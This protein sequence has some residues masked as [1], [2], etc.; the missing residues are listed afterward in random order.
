MNRKTNPTPYRLALGLSGVLLGCGTLQAAEPSK[1][2]IAFFESKVRPV[3]VNHCYRCHSEAEGSTKGG[4]AL[5][6]L[7]ALMRGGDSGKAVVPGQ[8]EA[9][10]LVKAIQYHDP[11]LQ[12]PPKEQ[13]TEDQV[14][15]LTQWVIIGAPFPAGGPKTVERSYDADTLNHWA[16][17]PVLDLPTP[18]VANEAWAV[19]D[20]DR[21]ILSKQEAVG[22]TPNQEA[23]KRILLRRATYDLTGLP[24]TLKEMDDF[25]ADN[26]PKAFEKVVDRL[27]KSPHYGE[28]WGRHWLDVARYADTKGDAQRDSVYVYPYAWAYRDYVIKSFNE[29]KPFDLFIKEQIAADLMEPTRTDKDPW[30]YAAL[31]FLTVGNR[32]DG[33]QEEIVNDRIDTLSKAFLGLTVACA[34]CHDHKFDPI[35]TSDYYSWRGIMLSIQ[36]PPSDSLPLLGKPA[37]TPQFRQFLDEYR[38][39]QEELQKYYTEDVNKWLSTTRE[40]AAAFLVALVESKGNRGEGINILR[41]NK[42]NYND[43]R[44]GYPLWQR[45]VSDGRDRKSPLA[46][47]FGPWHE[48][49][50]VPDNARFAQGAAKVIEDMAKDR[51][52]NPEVV[53]AF[54]RVVPRSMTQVAQ[55]YGSIFINAEKQMETELK[56]RPTATRLRNPNQEALRGVAYMVDYRREVEKPF[57]RI[58]RYLP[59]NLQGKETSILNRIAELEMSHP[60]APARAMVVLDK[61]APVISPI[62]IRGE[63]NNRGEDVPHRFLKLFSNGQE[64]QPYRQT[65]SGRLE[66]AQDIADPRNP[67][68][69]RVLVNRV[70]QHHFGEGLVSTPDD[71][72]V[73]SDPPSHPELLDHLANY[74]VRNGW[75]IKKL[76]RYIM[77]SMTYRQSSET[78]PRLAQI[79]PDNK[80]LWRA[81]IR[82]LEFESI[83]DTLLALGGSLDPSIGGKPFDLENE[84]STRRTVYAKLDRGKLPEVLNHFNFANPDMTSGKRYASTVPQQ[85]L[86]MMNS[87]LVV[88]LAKKLVERQDFTRLKET[89]KRI[90]LLYKL[91]YQRLPDEKE[92]QLG[93]SFIGD[94][95]EVTQ[96]ASAGATQVAAAQRGKGND[97]NAKRS[98]LDA[99]EEYAHALLQTNEAIFVN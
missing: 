12:M 54:R 83:R 40:N 11:D 22:L 60:G 16:F 72:G 49:D 65:R 80:L 39:K 20:I 14:R 58:Q 88:E 67:L 90:E 84:N 18:R 77:T 52:L 94:S 6:S 78:N 23:E 29:D 57:D 42:M 35:P 89:E 96:V 1:A 92:I 59:R 43:A 79:D 55:I 28:R 17:K 4:L 71:F 70:W 76:H 48:F 38:K 47:I 87:P 24:P 75:S 41:K 73:M 31:G 68:T 8:P 15:S 93:L 64:P 9:S 51:T 25:V 99:W 37:D 66:L 13:L 30:N 74:F 98:P 69:A 97:K 26:S 2:Q 44:Y 5:D 46:A 95:P 32:F 33:Q 82:Q 63:R 50:K 36:E 34:R 45:I 27:L 7:D 61:N 3:L 62:F 86:F 53:R 21:F 56:I 91:V 19:N 85:A 10:L 81:N